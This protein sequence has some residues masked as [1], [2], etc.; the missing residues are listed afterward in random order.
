MASSAAQMIARPAPS[1]HRLTVLVALGDAQ[2]AEQRADAL[3]ASDDLLPVLAGS[4]TGRPADVAVTDDVALESRAVGST[5][6][7]LPSGPSVIEPAP[8]A[9]VGTA[10][11]GLKSLC[12]SNMKTRLPA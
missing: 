1:A 6:Q 11:E 4:G 9:A 7:M 10:N 2:R 5:N 8:P 12:G 3:A